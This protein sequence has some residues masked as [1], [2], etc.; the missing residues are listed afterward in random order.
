MTKSKDDSDVI[1]KDRMNYLITDSN[2]K[3]RKN[4]NLVSGSLFQK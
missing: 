3:A 1:E 2:Y 4:K